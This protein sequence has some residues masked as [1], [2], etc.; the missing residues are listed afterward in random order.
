MSA[1]GESAP[2][3]S[4]RAAATRRRARSSWSP[5]ASGCSSRWPM[6]P[7]PRAMPTWRSPTSSSARAC[8]ARRST[9][10]SPTRRSASWP[11]TTR[12][13]TCCSGAIAR[14]RRGRRR[15]LAGARAGTEVYLQLLADN[16]DFART[17]LIEVLGAGPPRWSGAT[18]CTSASPTAWP[19]R[20]RRSPS[21]SGGTRPPA[22]YI[23]RAAVGAIHELVLDRLLKQG[24]EALPGLL[25]AMLEVE[26]R[27]LGA[28]PAPTTRKRPPHDP[29]R[30]SRSHPGPARPRRRLHARRRALAPGVPDA[31]APAR[32]SITS[33]TTRWTPRRCR[34]TSST[35]SASRRCRSASPGRCWSTAS[36]PRGE[37]YVP[38][39]TAEGTLVA[40]YNRGMKL[41]HE[42]GGVTT[43]V[44]EDRM[45]RA[46]AFVFPSAR[47]A[48]AFGVWLIEHFDE[49]KAVAETTTRSGGCR[50]S[51]ST[52]RSRILYTRFNYT[53]GDAAGQNLTGKATQAACD[54]IA[55]G[56]RASSSGSWSRT[57]RPTRRPRRSTCCTRAASASWPRR[58]SPT[59]CSAR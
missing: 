24:A 20:T 6:R 1:S 4:C 25:D 26:L 57:S 23:F 8:R 30:C 42:A 31:N 44:I 52:P 7:R 35:S 16:P 12:A 36:T 53:T 18:R 21:N 3:A 46:P 22:P 39:A 13:S 32:R 19:R 47:E 45:Q 37:F 28:P 27:L 15:A 48:R 2:S 49:I 51:S 54:W 9:S 43:T 58:R 59:S 17:F 33:A 55:A 14:G 11:P 56:I 41:L 50:T 34:A 10:T 38:L 29:A 5:S 40:S